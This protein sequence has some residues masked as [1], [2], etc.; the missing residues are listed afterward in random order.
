MAKPTWPV[1]RPRMNKVETV[2]ALVGIILLAILASV[3]MLYW[4]G[5]LFKTGYVQPVLDSYWLFIH[6]PLVL[7]AYGS[8]AA[9]VV[10]SAIALVTHKHFPKVVFWLQLIAVATFGFGIIT[11]ALWANDS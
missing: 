4:Y 9:A 11:G 10:C 5:R 1:D 7:T 3:L 8:A 2:Y 6:V